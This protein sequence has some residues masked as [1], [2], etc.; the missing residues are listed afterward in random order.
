M[1][2]KDGLAVDIGSSY[3]KVVLGNKQRISAFG[4]IKTPERSVVDNNIVDAEAIKNSLQEF[5][6]EK[7]WKPSYVSFV[8]HGQDL[9]IKHIEVP[10]MDEKGINKA[11]EM[12]ISQ[13]LPD[14]GDKYYIDFEI[15]SKINTKDKK[16]YNLLIGAAP[17]LKINK[18]VEIAD[19]LGLK[20]KAIDLSANCNARVFKGGEKEN[21]NSSNIAIIDIGY[22]SC[23]M[24]ILE[25]GN[26][27]IEREIT[28]GIRNAIVDIA[29]RL[30]IDE[31]EAF[32]YLFDKFD[33]TYIRQDNY[34]D[35]D[36]QMIFDNVFVNFEKI[37]QFFATGKLQRK[38]DKIYLTGGGSEING[39]DN[40]IRDFFGSQV[41]SP[42]S[43]EKISLKIKA[44]VGF[45]LKMYSCALGLLLRKE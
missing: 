33:F 14:N 45:T 20:L 40:Y 1:F 26:L 32:G 2:L 24:T 29:T 35:K 23:K 28:S 37:V 21:Q 11:V 5:I 42:D 34:L 25:N 39:I 44:P 27:F 8:I 9:I 31:E 22:R 36:I 15:Q 19:G 30:S 3:I 41:Y 43:T 6:T 18:Y 17:K 10:I 7:R 38:L 13:I 12:E 16:V 4:L